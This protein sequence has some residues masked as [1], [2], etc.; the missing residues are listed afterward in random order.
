MAESYFSLSPKD[1]AEVL[2]KATDATGRPAYLL[3]KD[4]WV[5][6]TL[7]VLFTQAFGAHLVFKGGTSLSKAYG[8]ILNRFSEDIDLTYDIRKLI[9]DLVGEGDEPLPPS[10]SQ[11]RKWTKAARAALEQWVQEHVQPAVRTALDAQGL[12]A[13]LELVADEKGVS[14]KLEYSPVTPANDYVKPIVVMEFGG[15]S[16]GE[17]AQERNVVCDAATAVPAVS[18]PEAK[19]RVMAAERTFWEKATAAHVYCRSGVLSPRYARHWHDLVRLDAAGIG[20]GAIADRSLAKQVAEHK[21]AFFSEKD[22]DRTTI[23]YD[24]AINGGLQLVPTGEAL[25][26]LKEDYESMVANGLLEGTPISFDALMANCATLTDKC[27]AAGRDA[28]PAPPA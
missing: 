19:P 16:T 3:E 27:N 25:Q 17:P 13:K 8:D 4:V 28:L 6:W 10:N 23:A 22:V 7:G 12:D 26:H 15:R 2:L 20:D 5:V 14:L 21:Q 1:Q 24:E 9:P 11:Q 18:F